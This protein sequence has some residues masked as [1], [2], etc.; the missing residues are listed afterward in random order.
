MSTHLQLINIIIIII[1]IVI[2]TDNTNML[3]AICIV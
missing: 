1:I 2:V 3:T